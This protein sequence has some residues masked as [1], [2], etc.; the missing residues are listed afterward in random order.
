MNSIES[1]SD[2][3]EI[4]F[5]VFACS[6]SLNAIWDNEEDDVYSELLTGSVYFDNNATRH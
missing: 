5:W 4:E 6:E 3:E 1:A 2:I